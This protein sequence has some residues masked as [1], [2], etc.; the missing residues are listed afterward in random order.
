MSHYDRDAVEDLKLIKLDLLSVRGL[1][2]ISATKTGLGLADPP[3]D[4]AG[5]LRPCSSSARTIGCFQVE[6]PAMM[7]LLRRM[8]PVRPARPDRGP[9]PHPARPDRERHEGGPAAGPRGPGDAAA[10]RSLSGSCRRPGG[11][12][13][14]EEQVMQIA[15]RV[16]G[17]PARGGRPPAADASSARASAARP[18]AGPLRP[19]GP[20]AGLHG[21]R[22]RQALAGHGE[23]LV[24]LLQQGPQRLVR[25]HG[26]PGRLPQG[27]SPRAVHG[28]RAQRRRR[29]L[30]AA[31]STSRRP[32]GWASASWG[33]TSTGAATGSRSRGRPSGS[34]SAR[35]RGW[36]C[37]R[38]T[39]SSRSGGRGAISPPSR[40]SWPGSRSPRPSS[41]PWSRPAS[42]TRSRPAGRGRSCATSRGST[43]VEPAS[44]LDAAGEGQDAPRVAGLQPGGRPA[45]ALRGQAAGPAHQGPAPA[46]RAAGRARGPGRRR[47]GQGGPRRPE[48]FLPLRGRDRNPRGRGRPARA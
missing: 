3:A 15:E 9:G 35:S 40:I 38:R 31:P 22:G 28:R 29:L 37:G 6:S 20:G 42:S 18:A 16:A 47:P 36:P 14:Y 12:L 30:P 8:K 1:A 25:G 39:R 32:S 34:A 45:G 41:S 21:R 2:A 4:D 23:V 7:N 13:L 46:R 17:M 27:P 24:L 43:G 26:L 11:L 5:R 10:T 44:D 19:G 33:R 48:V